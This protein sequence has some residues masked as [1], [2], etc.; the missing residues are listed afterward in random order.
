MKKRI[1]KEAKE[2]SN[3]FVVCLNVL[4]YCIALEKEKKNDNS[5]FKIMFF[6]LYLKKKHKQK[7]YNYEKTISLIKEDEI[8]VVFRGYF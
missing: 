2:L 7:E 5:I 1:R 3:R 6:L 8:I 4:F